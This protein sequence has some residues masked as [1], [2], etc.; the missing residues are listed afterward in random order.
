MKTVIN[1]KNKEIIRIQ[2]NTGTQKTSEKQPVTEEAD[3]EVQMIQMN[4]S[5]LGMPGWKFFVVK[6]K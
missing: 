6:D 1:K 5:F 3:V 4:P 2:Q